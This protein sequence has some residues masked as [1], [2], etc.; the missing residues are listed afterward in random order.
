MAAALIRERES[1]GAFSS[2][3]DLTRVPGIGA[4]TVNRLRPYLDFTNVPSISARR[5]RTSGGGADAVLEGGATRLDL[6]LASPGELE[7]LPG[8]GPALATRI[9]E[10][11][12]LRGRFRSVDDLL[13]VRGIGPVTL[14]RLKPRLL[15]RDSRR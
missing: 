4:A 5:R 10:F 3:E 15:V 14:E 9:V 12:R 13:A 11:R 8:I 6:N 7:G 2:E 1:E